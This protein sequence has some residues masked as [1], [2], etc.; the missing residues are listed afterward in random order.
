MEKAASFLSSLLGTIGDGG[1]EGP[2][3][4]PTATVAPI[5]I[6]PVKSCKGVSVP[7]SPVTA[8]GF[9]W[10]RQWLVVNA[11]GRALTQRVEPKMALVEVELPLAAF[12]EDWQPAPRLLPGDSNV[13][14]DHDDPSGAKHCR[15]C[16]NQAKE[17][18]EAQGA[19]KV[20]N[21]ELWHACTGPLICLPQ[22]GSLVYYFPQGHSEQADKD[23]YEVYA[24]MTLQPVNSE[25]DVFPIQS[26]GS[27]AKSKHPAEYFCKNL[28]ASDMSMHGGFSVPRRAAGKLFPQLDYS[29][30]PPNQELI[31]EDLHDN[32]WILRHIYHD[33]P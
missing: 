31:V 25:T 21:S 20:I 18:W 22:R 3:G 6:Y 17:Q 2:S 14:E 29:M 15:H 10:D 13:Y 8:T 30:Q 9:R 12:D 5:L 24:E 23:T 33:V 19:K 1:E 28:T 11:K 16:L 32:M 7:Q 4:E 26:L 27:Y